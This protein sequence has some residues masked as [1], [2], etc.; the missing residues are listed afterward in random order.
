MSN[1]ITNQVQQRPSNLFIDCEI[2]VSDLTFQ[3]HPQLFLLFKGNGTCRSITARNHSGKRHQASLHQTILEGHAQTV[4][5]GENTL[6]FSDYSIHFAT[7]RTHIRDALAQAT[8][9]SMK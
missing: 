3:Y 2:N 9:Q 8:S 4:L 5:T 7:Q 6:T 1:G